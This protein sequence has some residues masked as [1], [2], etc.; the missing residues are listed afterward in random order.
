MSDKEVMGAARSDPDAQ[1]LTPEQLAK[2]RRVSRVK[3]LR[4][5]LG[6]T[7]A[8]FAEAFHLP[9][10]TLRDWEQRR[11]TPDAPARALLLAIE[12]N[13][14]VMRRLLADSAA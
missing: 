14:K 10:T 9:I 2:M 1:P 5:R 8:E 13:P 11:S 7:Q 6:M 12:R 4:Q 3:V